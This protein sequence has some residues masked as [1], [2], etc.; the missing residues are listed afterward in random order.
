MSKPLGS[1]MMKPSLLTYNKTLVKRQGM[2]NSCSR[3]DDYSY[4]EL[5][6]QVHVKINQERT[7]RGLPL[8]YRNWQLTGLCN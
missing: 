2:C 3:Y 7:S 5:E 6:A 1:S 4:E 8:L